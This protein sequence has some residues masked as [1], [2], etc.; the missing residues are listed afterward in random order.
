V[1]VPACVVHLSLSSVGVYAHAVLVEVRG[2]L[3]E[4]LLIFHSIKAA[5][6]VLE[7]TAPWQAADL[8]AFLTGI[9]LWG[10]QP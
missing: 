10:S 9:F 4:L 5:S 8:Q 6:A 1:C 2:H 7:T 3:S